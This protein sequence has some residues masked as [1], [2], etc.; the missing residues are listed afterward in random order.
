[1]DIRGD[2]IMKRLMLAAVLV[3]FSLMLFNMA[4]I[5]QTAP[6]AGPKSFSVANSTIG[7]LLDNPAAKAVF[8]K[9]LP[10]VA[11]NPDIDQGRGM[12]LPEIVQYVPDLTPDKLAAI[13]ADLKALPAQ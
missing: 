6:A 13:D 5:A 4:V 2:I 8:V 11:S 10:D 3:A 12:T 7:D 1:M 9:Y